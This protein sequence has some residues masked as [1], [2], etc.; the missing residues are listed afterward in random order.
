MSESTLDTQL[1]AKSNIRP[2]TQRAKAAQILIW[3]VMALNVVSIISSYMQY[4]LLTAFQNGVIIT[5]EAA[6]SN[7]FREQ[8]VSIIYLIVF[9]VSIVTFIQWFRRA[10][11]NL[12]QRTTCAH[13]EGWAA[14]SWF[15]PIINWFRPY[16]IM[17]E[18]WDKTTGLITSNSEENIKKGSTSIIGWWWALWIF[19]NVIGNYVTRTTFNAETIESF[20]NASLSDMILSTVKIPL[21]ILA[22]MMIKAYAEKEEKLVV[23]EMTEVEEEV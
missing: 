15:V 19:S 3:S 12:S 2:N 8:M 22:V 11:Y 4:N 17:K 7:D 23:I 13:S 10:Y 1:I 6:N 9:I 16:Q 21:A 18:M 14:G 20:I 5:D